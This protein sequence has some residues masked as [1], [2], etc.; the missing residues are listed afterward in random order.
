MSNHHPDDITM[1]DYTAG[2]LP[3]AQS[4]AIAVHLFLC[5]SCRSRAAQ[6]NTLG[7]VVL[8]QSTPQ[9]ISVQDFDQFMADLDENLTNTAEPTK[10]EGS[11]QHPLAQ[12]LPERLTDIN[13]RQQ[14]KEIAEYDLS[15]ALG[16]SGYRVA[17]QKI[18]AGAR[19]PEHTHKGQELTVILNGGFSD[20]LGVYHAGDFIARDASHKHTPTAL[21]NEDCICLTVLDAPIKFTGPFLRWFNLFFNWK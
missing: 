14:T 2:T 10:M 15:S 12:F 20:E 18:K 7:G 21:Q 13:W 3:M 1:L 17:L 6:L 16:A 19:V 8:E 9:N 11:R 4:L 5:E